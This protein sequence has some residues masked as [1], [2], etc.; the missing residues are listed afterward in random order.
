MVNTIQNGNTDTIV[1]IDGLVA[2]SLSSVGISPGRHSLMVNSM[3]SKA[4]A[5]LVRAEFNKQNTLNN[6]AGNLFKPK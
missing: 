1:N 6:E 5:N 2:R 3:V 4:L